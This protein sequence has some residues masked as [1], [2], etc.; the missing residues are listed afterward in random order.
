MRSAPDPPHMATREMGQETGFD[1]RMQRSPK[2]AF[3]RRTASSAERGSGRSPTAPSPTPS[4]S[5]ARIRISCRPSRRAMAPLTPARTLSA[6]V[7]AAYTAIPAWTALITAC[8]TGSSRLIRLRPRKMSGWCVTTRSAPQAAASSM[9]SGVQSN[10][11][12][13]PWTSS[14]G[15]PITRPLLS[16]CSWMPSGANAS[17]AP[18]MSPTFIRPSS[19][20][21][22]GGGSP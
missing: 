6:V 15:E 13:T 18:M 22:A 5:G 16:Q 17:M 2:H 1:V 21:Q 12:R 4:A 10:P 7:W 9:S 11:T 14:S 20:P 8:P 3:T 19:R